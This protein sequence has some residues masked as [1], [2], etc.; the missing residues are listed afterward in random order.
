MQQHRASSGPHHQLWQTC[1]LL[2]VAVDALVQK[3]HKVETMCV[4]TPMFLNHIVQCHFTIP[5]L[6]VGGWVDQAWRWPFYRQI[7]HP[8]VVWGLPNRNKHQ[9]ARQCCKSIHSD[10]GPVTS[11]RYPAF[12][13]MSLSFKIYPALTISL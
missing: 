4:C 9:P 13:K 12:C 1:A 10:A 3:A 6:I 8:A 7:P 11:S 5:Q 2:L